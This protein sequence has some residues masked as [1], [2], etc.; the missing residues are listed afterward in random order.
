MRRGVWGMLEPG[1]GAG[2]NSNGR[3]SALSSGII[4]HVNVV[5]QDLEGM[6]TFFTENFG[7]TAGAAKD[8]EGAWVAELTGYPG[9]RAR[10]IPLT[11]TG[12]GP[13]ATRIELLAYLHPTTPPPPD[14]NPDLDQPGYRH[15]GFVVEDNEASY[16]K[17]KDE[18]RFFSAPVLVAEM[19]LKTVYFVGPE[20]IVIQLLQ[21]LSG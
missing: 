12:A 19:R 21:P 13:D 18:W 9:A 14:S 15:I 20:E 6:A 5:T 10:Y 2:S 1:C 17:L 4:N 11:P 3:R 8:L 7:F 16:Q